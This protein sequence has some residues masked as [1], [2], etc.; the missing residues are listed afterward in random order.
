VVPVK[1]PSTRLIGALAPGTVVPTVWLA[2]ALTALFSAM[3]TARTAVAHCASD[4]SLAPGL[5]NPK[6][7]EEGAVVVLVGLTPFFV[8]EGDVAVLADDDAVADREPAAAVASAPVAL[9]VPALAAW[10]GSAAQPATAASVAADTA[11]ANTARHRRHGCKGVMSALSFNRSSR[12]DDHQWSGR[13]ERL[14]GHA[15]KFRSPRTPR[16]G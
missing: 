15:E 1:F 4:G 11:V 7:P 6:W 2:V 12:P 13:R 5:S 8:G 3:A 10:D 9:R 16:P 14:L